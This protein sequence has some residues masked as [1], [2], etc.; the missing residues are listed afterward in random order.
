MHLVVLFSDGS[1]SPAP[2]WSSLPLSSSL[3]GAA[4]SEAL[5]SACFWCSHGPLRLPAVRGALLLRVAWS[6]GFA[7]LGALFSGRTEFRSATASTAALRTCRIGWKRAFCSASRMSPTMAVSTAAGEAGSGVPVPA[8]V[9]KSGM[10]DTMQR[11]A[12]MASC[13]TYAL[14]A[15]TDRAGLLALC[16]RVP[17]PTGHGVRPKYNAAVLV[18]RRAPDS[19]TE[20]VE[21]VVRTRAKRGIS[22]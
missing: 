2:S 10:L 6:T 8:P 19:S 21:G 5:P 13:F 22:R 17:C 7:R 14:A 16:F 1:P 3:D 11:K 12:Q 18:A 15:P 20:A 4:P 9:D